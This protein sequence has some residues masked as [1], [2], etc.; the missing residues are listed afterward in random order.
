MTKSDPVDV[1]REAAEA[2]GATAVEL[3]RTDLSV[4]TKDG[5]TDYV[6]RADRR[7]QRQVVAV[8]RGTYPEA[9]VVGEENDVRKDIPQSGLAWIVDPID[10]T[11]NYLRG[12]R[13]WATS[14]VAVEDSEPIAAASALPA[15]GDTYIAGPDGVRRNGETASVSTR[16]D[17]ETFAVVPTVWW[18]FDRRDEYAAVTEAI[19]TRFGD[20][21]R[22]KSAQIA[23]ALV[24]AGSIEGAITNVRPNPW[25]S[26]A[27]AYMVQQAGGTVTDI[28]GDV[29]RH[30][31]RGLVASNGRAHGDVLAAAREA[32]R[33]RE[34]K[35]T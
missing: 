24:A 26:V 25:D 35:G 12:L 11:N 8:I 20:L 4:D 14:V 34:R 5:K 22:P 29:W 32:E 23:L 1:A 19:V 2:G 31:S 16:T 30:D 7:T 10:G 13:H 15:V 27:G 21:V 18:D 33:L 17:P 3:F 6:T 28:D 9:V